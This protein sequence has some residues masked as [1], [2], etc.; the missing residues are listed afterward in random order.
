MIKEINAMIKTRNGFIKI[1]R[2]HCLITLGLLMT[3]IGCGATGSSIVTGAKRPS[4]STIQVQLY[5]E[6]PQSYEVIGIVKARSISGSTDQEKQNFALEELK[7]QA[8][9]LGA[10]GIILMNI[11]EQTESGSFFMP[12][13]YGG[14]FIPITEHQ[15]ILSGKAIYV[16]H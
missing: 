14:F 11:G 5:L 3:I 13:R 4:I 2:Y 12:M 16:K 9:A 15:A 1:L 6:P 7:R 8:S 10:N